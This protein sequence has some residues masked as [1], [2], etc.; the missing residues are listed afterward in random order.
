M[1]SSVF[2]GSLKNKHWTSYFTKVKSEHKEFEFKKKEIFA[3][4]AAF[5]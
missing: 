5:D 1:H 3:A 2:V 4:Q